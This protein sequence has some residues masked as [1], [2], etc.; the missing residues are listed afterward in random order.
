MHLKLEQSFKVILLAL[1]T[2]KVGAHTP[3]PSVPMPMD[4]HLKFTKSR[5]LA[6]VAM[7]EKSHYTA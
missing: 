5:T 7:L 1:S 3:P 4:F 2:Q 6:K